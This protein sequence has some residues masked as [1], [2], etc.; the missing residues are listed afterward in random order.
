MSVDKRRLAAAQRTAASRKTRVAQGGSVHG[1]SSFRRSRLFSFSV[2]AGA[3]VAPGQ[4]RTRGGG[5]ESRAARPRRQFERV[6]ANGRT[7]S[8]TMEP[9]RRRL[10]D[11]APAGSAIC[12]G[13]GG[14]EVC[15]ISSSQLARVSAV[16]RTTTTHRFRSPARRTALITVYGADRESRCR[17]CSERRRSQCRLVHS[18]HLFYPPLRS[19]P[20]L[21]AV[22]RAQT[23]IYATLFVVL[24][25]SGL[26][27]LSQYGTSVRFWVGF[28]IGVPVAARRLHVLPVR[29]ALRPRRAAA[30]LPAL[31]RREDRRAHPVLQ[32]GPRARRGVD[33]H[34]ARRGGPKAGDRDR[35]RL[36]ERRADASARAR[37]PSCRSRCTSSRKTAAS[38]RR[39]TTPSPT[40]STTTSTSSSRSTATRCSSR[41]RWCASSSRCSAPRSAPRRGTCCCSTSGRTCSRAWSAPT[42]GSGSTSTSR[43]SR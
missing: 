4:A 11:A 17:S 24:A 33:P 36:D 22:Q 14:R 43:R 42:T 34:R 8:R 27:F 5:R 13:K 26:L 10:V 39:C 9:G 20:E 7:R 15:W 28:T 25:G 29:A 2:V 1:S 31:R 16:Y 6:G 35:R 18:E 32:R 3:A 41:T 30:A 37:A 40:C 23:A 12:S 38:A 19:E 21:N